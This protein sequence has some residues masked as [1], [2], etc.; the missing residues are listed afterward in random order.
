M[1]PSFT[2][3]GLL[4]FYDNYNIFDHILMASP[5]YP[6]PWITSQLLPNSWQVA[7][8]L[9]HIIS[10]SAVS[11]EN[12]G[13]VVFSTH[14]S[15]FLTLS[16][17]L[18]P[19]LCDLNLGARWLGLW[20]DTLSHHASNLCQVILKT[21]DAWQTRFSNASKHRLGNYMPPCYY[22]VE[23]KN[24]IKVIWSWHFS[25]WTGWGHGSFKLK[26]YF[27]RNKKSFIGL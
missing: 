25:I 4:A 12:Y 21:F 19:H 15:G 2:K 27:W 3:L 10:G 17:D 7:N 16:A 5:T 13:S 18:S 1:D 23:H 26:L 6:L 24:N 20:H 22:G 11:I 9:F 8:Y 14:L